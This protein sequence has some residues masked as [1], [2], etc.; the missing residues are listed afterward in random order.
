MIRVYFSAFSSFYFIL[1]LLKKFLYKPVLKLLKDRKDS[2]TEGIQKAEEA[3]LLLEKAQK[4]EKEIL[5]RA[6]AQSEKIQE[7]AKIAVSELLKEAREKAK[8]NT[9]QMILQAKES[10]AKEKEKVENELITKVSEL[11]VTFLKK[12]L[13]QTLNPKTQK[14]IMTQTLTK[15]KKAD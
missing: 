1:F 10:I 3:R 13:S 11:S 15:L 4:E 8:E 5:Q 12:A 2:I 14:E 7:Q 9:E 6:H